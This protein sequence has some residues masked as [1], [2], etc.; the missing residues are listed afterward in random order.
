MIKSTVMF[1]FDHYFKLIFA[2]VIYI[3]SHAKF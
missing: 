2:F 1:Q 3:G